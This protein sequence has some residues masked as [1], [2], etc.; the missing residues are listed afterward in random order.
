MKAFFSRLKQFKPALEHIE[1][2]WSK[3]ILET[4]ASEILSMILDYM[5]K[6]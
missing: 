2:E 6:C 1:I 5:N 4:L 3:I